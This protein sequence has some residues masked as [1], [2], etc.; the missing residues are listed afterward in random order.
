M[1]QRHARHPLIPQLSPVVAEKVREGK[2]FRSL[3]VSFAFGSL[4]ELE[5]FGAMWLCPEYQHAIKL[6]VLLLVVCFVFFS[7]C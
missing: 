4:R 7:W 1:Q 2:A 6:S 3:P 5:N